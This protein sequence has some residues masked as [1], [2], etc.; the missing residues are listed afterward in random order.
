MD[1]D[2][3]AAVL[4]RLKAPPFRLTQLRQAVFRE[5]QDSYEA[6]TTLP[7]ELRRT[8]AAEAPLLCLSPA[9]VRASADGLC[10]KALL[11]LRDGLKIETVL[12]RPSPRRWTVCISSQA[13]C[14]VA[15]T[16]CATG[17]MGLSRNLSAEEISD[18]VLFWKQF[19]RREKIAGGGTGPDNVVYMGMGEPFANYEPVARSLRAL[20][21]QAQFG[22]GARHISVSTSG[23]APKIERFAEDFPQVNLALSLHA[24]EDELRTRLVPMNKAYPLESLAASLR[25]YLE[26]TGR[27]VFV[28]YVLL[29]GENDSAQDARSLA[30][31]LR[32]VGS[33]ERL[34]VN[35]IAFNQTDTPHQAPPEAEARRFQALLRRCGIPT[36]LRRNLGQDIDG[37]CGQ[38]LA[39]N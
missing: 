24:A 29:R 21:D 1:V 8:L 6:M 35:L 4:K 31:Y 27:K 7:E 12:L 36:T 34:H 5:A 3:A 16:F 28:E 25:V 22:L 10:R 38:L 13:G 23:I 15:C 9:L 33:L 11:R 20:M 26:R 32:S 17:L 2:K 37:A 14:A 30:A 18:Q 19:T 39:K